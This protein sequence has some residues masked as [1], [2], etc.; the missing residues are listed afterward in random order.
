MSGLSGAN[1]VICEF[2]AENVLDTLEPELAEFILATSVSERTCG[3]LASVLA[4]T[5]RGRRCSRKSSAAGCS[6]NEVDG[7]PGWF[8]YH[9]MFAE[10]LRR[11]LERDRPDGIGP[12]HSCASSWFAEHGYLSEAVDH[13]LAAGDPE[14]A[15]QLVEE[16]ET[17][18]LSSPR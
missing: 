6:S 8:R 18:L 2:L 12:L 10:F 3:G 5:A 7:D 4:Q 16:D 14:T 11:R 1:D 13:A 9:Q 17:R 15:V